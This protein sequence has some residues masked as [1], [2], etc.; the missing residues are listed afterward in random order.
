MPELPEVEVSRLGIIPYV[1]GQTVTDITIRQPKLRW[2]IP[3]AL[4]Q[5]KGQV[6]RR[7]TRRAK[8]LLLETDV[9]AA[10]IH[11][12]MSGS[13]RVL[14]TSLAPEKHDHVDVTLSNGRLLRY[15]DP[16]RFGAWLWQDGETPHTVLGK[17]GPEPLTDA[18]DP[19]YLLAKATG[20][21]MAMKSFIMDNAVVVG[22]GNIYANESLFCAGIHPKR[23]AGSL[24][25]TEAAC[26]VNEI[27]TVLAAAITQGGTTLKDFT[28]VDGKAG[29]FAQALRVYGKSGQPCPAC[30]VVLERIV[31]GQRATVFC[32]QC[33]PLG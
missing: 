32:P 20:K 14:P 7:V 5:L 28:Q 13:L 2:P 3:D 10:I 12:G 11:L 22:V 26:L 8:Y 19:D 27:K 33:Q 18:F 25:A 21:K 16:R 24:T 17:L 4:Q 31:I 29:Y 1:E 23:P 6:I 30:D 9:G 15:H